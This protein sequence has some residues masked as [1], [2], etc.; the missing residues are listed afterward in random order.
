MLLESWCARERRHGGRHHG[1]SFAERFSDDFAYHVDPPEPLR[2]IAMTRTRDDL[3]DL[4]VRARDDLA[5]PRAAAFERIAN[6]DFV[7]ERA[8]RID[9]GRPARGAAAV[10]LGRNAALH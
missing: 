2:G 3:V 8:Q 4:L 7:Q 1:S 9:V 10:E 5:R 6:K